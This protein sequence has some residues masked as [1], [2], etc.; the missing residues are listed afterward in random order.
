MALKFEF[1]DMNNNNQVLAFI[2]QRL[3]WAKKKHGNEMPL[4]G[5]YDLVDALEEALDLS[6]YLAAQIIH[7]K[8]HRWSVKRENSQ[9]GVSSVVS[10]A[11]KDKDDPWSAA[12]PTCNGE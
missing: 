9:N 12:C 7:I 10:Q 5:T 4:D 6:I 3:D 1:A 8:N 11:I 2:A